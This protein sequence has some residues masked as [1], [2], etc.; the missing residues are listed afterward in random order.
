MTVIEHKTK[1]NTLSLCLMSDLH[2]GGLHVDYDLIE[3]ELKRAKSI[4]AK[5]LINGDVFDA[6]MPGDRKRYRANNLHPRMFQAG[7]D[8]IGESIRWAIEILQPYKDDIIMIG[9][10]NHDDA[11]ARYHHIEPVKHLVI[12]LNGT[13]EPT[14]KYG[15]YH[16]FIHVKMPVSESTGR[17]RWANY[18][19]HYHHGAGGGAPVTKGAITFSRAAMWLEGV[20]AIWRGHTHQRQAGRD[21]KISFNTKIL[22]PSERVMT[23]DVLTLRTGSYID[24]YKGTSSEDLVK[25]GRK[26]GYAAL[27]DAP[28]LPKGG[29]TLHLRSTR[30]QSNP[31]EPHVPRVIDTLEI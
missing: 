19:I 2:I 25:H 12:A 24:T 5:I 21:S 28:N 3:S 20:D 29:L 14:V 23:K 6:I 9:D 7:D 13:G 1:T 30:N 27:W 16:G 31:D 10:G 8:M 18:V 4:G 22:V 26:D 15:G 17:A 11:V